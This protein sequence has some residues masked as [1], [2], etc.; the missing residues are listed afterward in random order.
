MVPPSDSV[1]DPRVPPPENRRH[2]C[3]APA[4]VTLFE[5]LPE[6]VLDIESA[7]VR[8][9]R[10]KVAD[11]LREAPLLARAYDDFA[12]STYLSLRAAIDPGEIGEVI[13]LQDEIGV[14][15]DLDAQGI[16]MGIEVSGYEEFL[17][18]LETR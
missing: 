7:L 17:A 3:I 4:P 5:A 11:Q 10:G 8:L 12:Q 13:S 9:G 18:R 1:I 14:S 6:L 2:A 15:L 16:V